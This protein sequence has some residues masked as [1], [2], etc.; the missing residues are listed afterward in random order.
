[1]HLYYTELAL[2]TYVYTVHTLPNSRSP[3]NITVCFLTSCAFLKK[4]FQP[5][6]QTTAMIFSGF[7]VSGLKHNFTK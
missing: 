6:L 7:D 4:S 3:T 5:D 1:M 2:I